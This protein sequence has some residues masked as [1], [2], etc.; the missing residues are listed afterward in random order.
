MAATRAFALDLSSLE[1]VKRCTEE[2]KG[3]VSKIDILVNNAGVMALPKMELTEDGFEKQIGINHFG[4]FA[5]TGQLFDLLK[6]S[7]NARIV[8]VASSAHLFAQID[9]SD[10]ML[11]KEGAYQSWRAYGN[12]K[13]ANILFTKE[14]TKRL[15]TQFDTNIAVLCCHPGRDPAP[16]SLVCVF[17]FN[18]LQALHI[19]VFSP[20][21]TFRLHLNTGV[22]RTEL[23]RYIFE[24]SALPIPMAESVLSAID[25]VG[26][27][28]FSES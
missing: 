3:T 24:P 17:T 4:H 9:K 26:R 22:C 27:P 14:L 11:L 7:G 20:F 19:M 12:S 13:L 10:L 15:Y 6:K 28:L 8:N 18:C 1:S 25:F 16:S 21:L 2:L 5:L 23:G